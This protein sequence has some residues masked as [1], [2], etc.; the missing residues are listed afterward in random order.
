MASV[1]REP[2]LGVWRQS[3]KRGLGAE[4][5]VRSQRG[6]GF[7]PEAKSIFVFQKYKLSANLPDFLLHVNYLTVLFKTTLLHFCHRHQTSPMV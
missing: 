2:I 3:P 4:S 7:A 1:E 6:R 5:L